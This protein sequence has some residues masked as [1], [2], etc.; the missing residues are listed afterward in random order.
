MIVLTNEI[1]TMFSFSNII[2]FKTIIYINL[3]RKP[4]KLHLK[5]LIFHEKWI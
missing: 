4:N 5:V 1:Q 2:K 3:I